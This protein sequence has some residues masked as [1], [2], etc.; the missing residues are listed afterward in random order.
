MTF[1]KLKSIC[2][3]SPLLPHS[4][5]KPVL[6]NLFLMSFCRQTKPP[7]PGLGWLQLQNPQCPAWPRRQ[8]HI[9]SHAV[10]TP[11]ARV[12]N[13]PGRTASGSPPSPGGET[14][15][16][17]QLQP[18][19]QGPP[20]SREWELPLFTISTVSITVMKLSCSWPH[21]SEETLLAVSTARV[22]GT[23]PLAN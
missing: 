18:T 9:S 23:A 19:Q 6:N 15:R 17:L 21:S 10:P 3:S 22:G 12:Q 7:V 20:E 5:A 13:E 14:L 1:L 2:S 16:G 4:V 11:S 8:R